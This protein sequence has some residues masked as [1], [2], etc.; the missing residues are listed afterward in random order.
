MSLPL[1]IH[2]LNI[3]NKY[4]GDFFRRVNKQIFEHVNN[5]L[6]KKNFR[7]KYKFKKINANFLKGKPYDSFAFF[8]FFKYN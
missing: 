3:L 4:R 1:F 6:G 2:F 7:Y 5:I 8:Q